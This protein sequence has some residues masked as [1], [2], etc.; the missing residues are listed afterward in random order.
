MGAWGPR[1]YQDDIAEEV[2]DYY[3]DQLHR[4]KTGKEIT[5]ELIAQN[6]YAISDP[7]DAP[8]FWFA[9]AD[10]QWNLGR[11]EDL[12]RDQAL[13]HIRDGYDVKRWAA[14]DP[15][16]AKTRAETLEK[17]QQKLLSPQPAEKK[18]AQ[19]KLYRC[20][21]KIGDVYAYRLN[22]DYAKENGMFGKF[23]YFIKVDEEV[24]HPGH[25][26]PVVYFYWI[27]G[28][29]LLSLNELKT[30]NYIPQFFVPEVYKR[31]PKRQRLYLLKL[32]STSLRVIPND[33]LTFIGNL[34]EIKRV[35]NE[36]PNSYQ[37]SWK[38]FERYIIDNFKKWNEC[39]SC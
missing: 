23:L 36:D 24:W 1:L 32:L 27:T 18:I 26:V 30:I 35:D 9:L 39:S 6:E 13:H 20:E 11:L 3:K 12:V 29:K 28:D 22:G 14:E 10:T 33:R 19:Y 15:Q 37:I 38:D 7:D 4:G 16:G 25:I 2:R 8:V 5:Q 17:L 34:Q 31:D 21:W